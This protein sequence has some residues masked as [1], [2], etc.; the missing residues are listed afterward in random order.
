[1]NETNFEY[2]KGRFCNPKKIIE[3]SV[4]SKQMPGKD[5]PSDYETIYRVAITLDVQNKDKGTLYSDGFDTETKAIEFA[6]TIPIG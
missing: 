2:A 1:M 5:N 3:V 4:Y 6:K